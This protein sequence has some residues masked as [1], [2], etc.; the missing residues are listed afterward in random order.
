MIKWSLTLSFKVVSSFHWFIS[1]GISTAVTSEEHVTQ[2][3]TGVKLN[4]PYRA[5]K[6]F[7]DYFHPIIIIYLTD[8][9]CNENCR[10]FNAANNVTEGHRDQLFAHVCGSQQKRCVRRPGVQIIRKTK[11]GIGNIAYQEKTLNTVI[12][13][14]LRRLK[15]DLLYNLLS[16]RAGLNLQK[17]QRN[18]RHCV[19]KLS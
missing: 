16:R 18:R 11:T 10:V 5:R 3:Y 17:L 19:W 6:T 15:L 13:N 2:L 8:F 12:K 4:S 1:K 14:I 9:S 7:R